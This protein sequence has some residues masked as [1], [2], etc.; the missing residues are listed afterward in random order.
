MES[1]T[2]LTP[3]CQEFAG[4][5]YY[6][7]GKYF[8]HK[9]KRLHVAVW[10]ETFG[11]VPPGFHVHHI[12][13]DRSHNQPT[14][15]QAIPKGKHLSLHMT[16][17]RREWSRRNMQRAIAAAPAW[18][19]SPEGK[20]WHSANGRATWQAKPAVSALCQQCGGAYETYFP[21]RAKFCS[22]ACKQKALRMR[23]RKA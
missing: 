3:T 11:P 23:R 7:C 15:L 12:D 13:E 18:H 20:A 9:G 17:E 6:L 8:Q 16:P 14:N 5:R 19:S 10:E 21:T 2:V 1:V 22:P 4:Q